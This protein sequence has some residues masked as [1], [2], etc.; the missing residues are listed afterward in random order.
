MVKP[1]VMLL[2]CLLPFSMGACAA[3]GDPEAPSPAMVPTPASGAPTAAPSAMPQPSAAAPVQIQI[4]V[5]D[6]SLSATLADNS[7]AQAFADL[8]AQGPV[9]VEMA[10]YGGFEKVGALPE[11]LVQNNE[12]I[13]TQPGDLILYQGQQVVIYY[14]E[15]SYSLTRLGRID[16][17]SQQDLMALLEPAD[18]R[19]TFSFD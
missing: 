9:A 5:G 18:V 17:I 6:T 11:A 15:N 10:D 3:P 1:L 7:S 19:V 4:Q 13:T 16:G 2:L 12:A 14:G 8:L